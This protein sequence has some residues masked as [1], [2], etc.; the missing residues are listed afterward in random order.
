MFRNCYQYDRITGTVPS[1]TFNWTRDSNAEA[2]GIATSGTGN[3]SGT[4]VNTTNAPV[5]VTFTITPK[6][7]GC[8]GTPVTATVLLNPKPA[9]TAT[10]ASQ[11]ICSGDA[12]SDIILSSTVT[13][14]TYTWTRN[15]TGVTG[16]PNS[17]TGDISAHLLT[18]QMHLL[19]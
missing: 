1:T 9:A 12:V 18:R 17:G 19:P 10:P 13:G 14:T 4:L 8:D 5:T 3:I 11:N 6:A 15:N 7:A 16:I 2:T